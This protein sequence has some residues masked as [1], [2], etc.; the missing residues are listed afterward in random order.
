MRKVFVYGDSIS[1]QY[2]FPLQELLEKKGV[3]YNRKG[4]S[5]SNDL[6]NPLWNGTTTENMLLW[7]N[8]I[9]KHKDTILVFNCGLHDIVHVNAKETCQ[10]L[11]DKYRDNLSCICEKAKA[12]FGEIVFVN[13][14][15]VEDKRHNTT[16]TWVRYNKDV[17]YYN[18][19]ATQVMNNYSV[20]IVDL[21]SYTNEERLK[22]TIYIDHVHMTKEVSRMQ[23]EMIV[24]K[25]YEWEYIDG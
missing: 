10:V 7:M 22:K 23:A 8:D 13:T 6:G 3:L 17:L 9:G 21:Y 25:L 4:G 14:T 5:N 16:E 15:P 24:T 18:E 11:P 20:N 2:G 12:L 19:I 1:M